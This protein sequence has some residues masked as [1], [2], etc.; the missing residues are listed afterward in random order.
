[1]KERIYTLSEEEY[2]TLA[3]EIK[4]RLNSPCYFSGTVEIEGREGKTLRFTASL[5]L[6]RRH[7]AETT[8]YDVHDTIYAVVPV[9]WDFL[10]EG[11]EGIIFDDF[12][13]AEFRKHLIEE[14]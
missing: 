6:Y 2:A 7:V 4:G 10:C 12:D 13:F 8:Q 11:E 1:M 9:W 5:I 14:E 3:E